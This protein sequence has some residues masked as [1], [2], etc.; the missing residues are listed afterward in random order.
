MVFV[1]VYSIVIQLF[2]SPEYKT[3]ILASPGVEKQ[4]LSL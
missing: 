3:E 2:P 1:C 4:E